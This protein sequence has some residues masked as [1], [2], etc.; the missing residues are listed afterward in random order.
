MPHLTCLIASLRPPQANIPIVW[1]AAEVVCFALLAAV[2][3]L[4]DCQGDEPILL[5]MCS[6]WQRQPALHLKSQCSHSQCH[7]RQHRSCT[8]HQLRGWQNS[9]PRGDLQC[10]WPAPVGCPTR[11]LGGVQ[12]MYD[13]QF[14]EVCVLEHFILERLDDKGVLF[15]CLASL[16]PSR[17]LL[18]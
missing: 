15:P 11:E 18:L 7:R 5:C 13:K 10:W 8:S 16:Q 2:G 14:Q 6:F 1:Y 4:S 17:W 3:E 12:V 9:K